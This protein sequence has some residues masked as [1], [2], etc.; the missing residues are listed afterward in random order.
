MEIAGALMGTCSERLLNQWMSSG[1][2]LYSCLSNTANEKQ[3]R[4]RVI[5]NA[6]RFADEISRLPD[7]GV[8]VDPNIRM[9]KHPG[10]KNRNRLRTGGRH[11]PVRSYNLRETFQTHRTLPY[12]ACEERSAMAAK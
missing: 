3:C 2:T 8:G 5:R 9:P 7:T 4:H 1:K 11:V 6:D 10:R 12:L